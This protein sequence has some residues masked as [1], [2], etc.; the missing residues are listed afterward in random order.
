MADFDDNIQTLLNEFSNITI[1]IKIKKT[2]SDDI[3]NPLIEI[4][5][6]SEQEI[7]VGFPK[8]WDFTLIFNRYFTVESDNTKYLKQNAIFDYLKYIEEKKS[9]AYKELDDYVI[10]EKSIFEKRNNLSSLKLRFKEIFKSY[11]YISTDKSEPYL[12]LL[13]NKNIIRTISEEKIVSDLFEK[14]LAN[15]FLAVQRV[16]IKSLIK[17][18]DKKLQILKVQAN[19]V[20]LDQME[21]ISTIKEIEAKTDMNTHVEVRKR[22]FPKKSFVYI[23]KLI[24]PLFRFN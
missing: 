2:C 21:A 22:I 11:Y 14:K 4:D 1:D 7:I 10:S 6:K 17:Y 9:L 19:S 5:G 24:D 15:S 13:D 20:K 23:P 3:Y 8:L 12:K 16:T 18:I